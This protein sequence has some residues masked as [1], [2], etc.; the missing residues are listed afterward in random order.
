MPPIEEI[1][2]YLWF[3]GFASIAGLL[4]HLTDAHEKGAKLS[5]YECFLKMAGSAFAGTVTIYGCL[6]FDAST[7]F[8]GAATGLAGWLGAAFVRTAADG[9]M[10]AVKALINRKV[11]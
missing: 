8:M 9:L 3:I 2:K 5:F 7:G 4:G 1:F 6:A 10:G 11:D